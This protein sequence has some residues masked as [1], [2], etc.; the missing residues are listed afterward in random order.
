MDMDIL[1]MATKNISKVLAQRKDAEKGYGCSMGRYRIEV[2]LST[3]RSDVESI[4]HKMN[5]QTDC[6]AIVQDG[7]DIS[8]E[9]QSG[10]NTVKVIHSKERGLS[11]SRNLAIDN[12]TGDIGL[13]ADDDVVYNSN[14]PAAVKDAY[15]QLP[16]ADL[17]VFGITSSHPERSKKSFKKKVLRVNYL[18]SLRVSSV[19]ISFRTD[20][21]HRNKIRF[22]EQFGAGAEFSSGE[23][24][25]FLFDCLKKRLR[26]YYYP[27]DLCKVH[28]NEPSSWFS[29]FDV[30]YFRNK[31][32]LSYKL[33][34]NLWFLFALQFAVRKHHLY[35][36][37]MGFAAAIMEMAR[38][39]QIYAS[40]V[41]S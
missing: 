28:F 30:K 32:A 20:S 40:K 7:R 36:N 3:V 15:R 22:S 16:E 17:I 2:L 12:A 8:A 13:F 24:N 38:G 39:R 37:N 27:F 4:L 9:F 18:N 5:V 19:M 31:G 6:V 23:E 41:R 29:G 35:K 33:F 1:H 34:G 11:K 10:S 21:I 26:I 25:I 14:Y